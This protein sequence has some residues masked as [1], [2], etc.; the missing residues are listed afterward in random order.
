MAASE[1]LVA[2]RMIPGLHLAARSLQAAIAELTRGA[3]FPSVDARRLCTASLNAGRLIGYL[4]AL[5]AA[6][7]RV[8]ASVIDELE[9]VFDSVEDVRRQFQQTV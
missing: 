8:A 5:E 7:A 4:E 9:P 1:E 2:R 3:P 6:D